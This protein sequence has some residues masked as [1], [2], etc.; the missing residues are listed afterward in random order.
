[1]HEEHTIGKFTAVPYV[2]PSPR[3]LQGQHKDR[4]LCKCL[5]T[6]TFTISTKIHATTQIKVEPVPPHHLHNQQIS[7][8]IALT[9]IQNEFCR[10]NSIIYSWFISAN[11]IGCPLPNV[12]VRYNRRTEPINRITGRIFIIPGRKDGCL[13]LYVVKWAPR[14]RLTAVQLSLI[15]RLIDQPLLHLMLRSV[16]KK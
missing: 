4:T 9:A 8:E 16:R 3:P 6:S 2:Q 10:S 11:S 1:M 5:W 14:A 13:I 7:I 15:E 12:E